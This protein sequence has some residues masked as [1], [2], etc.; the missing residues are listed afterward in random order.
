MK[1]NR[2]DKLRKLRKKELEKLISSS[3]CFSDIF[4]KLFSI[5]RSDSNYI[6]IVK[7]KCVEYQIDIPFL[8]KRPRTSPIWK[9]SSKEFRRIA[10]EAETIG[11]MFKY[12]GLKA[13]SNYKTIKQRF[14]HEEMDYKEYVK[15]SHK[16]T[17]GISTPKYSNEEMFQSNSS[18]SRSSVK[19]RILKDNLLKYECSICELPPAWKGKE[20]VLVLDHINGVHNDNRLENLRFVCPNCNAQLDTSFG[21]NKKTK[22]QKKLKS[23]DIDRITNLIKEERKSKLIQVKQKR[24]IKKNYCLNCKIRISNKSKTNLCRACLNISLQPKINIKEIYIK[25]LKNGY[26]ATG[27]EYNVTG[28]AVKKWL[29]KENL[30]PLKDK[31]TNQIKTFL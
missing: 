18:I 7:E 6:L 25:V 1:I 28:S 29:S 30:D 12:F 20:L 27:R 19:R 3:N 14:I 21:K 16:G 9:V 26:Q 13:H 5:N 15:R 10:E 2:I 8:N 24:I 23:K 4:K 31:K 22:I 17:I 11:N